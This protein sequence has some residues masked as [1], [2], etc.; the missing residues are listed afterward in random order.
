MINKK[1]L[2]FLTLFSMVLVLSI[3]YVTMPNELLIT[4]NGN[5]IVSTNGE[6]EEDNNN[7]EDSNVSIETSDV[8]SALKVEDESKVLDEINSLKKTLTDMNVDI[9]DKNDAFEK[10]KSI[11]M[12]NSLEE[13]IEAKLKEKYNKECFVKI[14]KDQVRVVM[15]SSEHDV[16]LANEIMRLVQ[17]NFDNKMYIS[18][19]FQK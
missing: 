8:I 19:Q 3:Y 2:W 14:E 1:N 11:N 5:N 6:V 16:S 4:N 10:L 9:N 13:K 15:G 7:D 12:N 18:V 17:E